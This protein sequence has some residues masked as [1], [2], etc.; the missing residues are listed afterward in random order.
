MRPVRAP[1]TLRTDNRTPAA[2]GIFKTSHPLSR[3]LAPHVWQHRGGCGPRLRAHTLRAPGAARR[4]PRA[5]YTKPGEGR[6]GPLGLWGAM[7]ALVGPMA[8]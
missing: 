4:V 8:L 7:G 5:T 6:R 1:I 3:P 2:A